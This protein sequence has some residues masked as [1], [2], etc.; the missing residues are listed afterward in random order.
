MFN[1]HP[2]SRHI[3]FLVWLLKT[4]ISTKKPCPH[5]WRHLTLILRARRNWPTL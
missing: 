2:F 4:S 3:K 1:H 5:F